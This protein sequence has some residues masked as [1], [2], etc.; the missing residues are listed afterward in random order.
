[1]PLRG[2]LRAARSL[3]IATPE[4]PQYTPGEATL[5]RADSNFKINCQVRYTSADQS[6]PVYEDAES[7]KS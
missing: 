1:L 6:T 7:S 3:E 2:S 5:H 4:V